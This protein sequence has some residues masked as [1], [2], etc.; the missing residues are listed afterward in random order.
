M[1][2]SKMI[3]DYNNE[4]WDF[5]NNDD[6]VDYPTEWVFNVNKQSRGMISNG[7]INYDILDYKN[8][9]L[10]LVLLKVINLR[11]NRKM[12]ILISKKDGTFMISIFD[13]E[14]RISYYF[15]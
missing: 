4:K 9:N 13:Y 6:F 1:G 11:L 7:K 5:I 8:V 12:D 2:T 14:E 15:L 3:W 10:S